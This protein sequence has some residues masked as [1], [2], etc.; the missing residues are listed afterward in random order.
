MVNNFNKLGIRC[1][2][3]YDGFYFPEGA[4]TPELFYQVYVQSLKYLKQ[5]MK[6]FNEPVENRLK[7]SKIVELTK[8][9]YK[10]PNIKL[11]EEYRCK[12]L[13]SA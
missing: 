12:T 6:E 8:K 7:R 5:L 1:L 9:D 11:I 2:N 4:M 3:V 10:M 13:K